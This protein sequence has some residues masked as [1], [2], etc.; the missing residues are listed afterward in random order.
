VAPLSAL[1]KA[2]A[3]L[4][5]GDFSTRAEPSGVA[6][7]DEAGD[8]LNRTAERLASLIDREQ[9]F[10]AQ[11]SHQLRTPLT[12]LQLELETGLDQGG[13][14][15]HD[16]A[17]SAMATADQ[18]SQT[19]DDVLLLSRQGVSSDSFNVEDL[20]E[21]CRSQWQGPLASVGRPLRVEVGQP[22]RAAASLPASRQIL[23]VLLDNAFRHGRGQVTLRARESHGAVAVDV[24][25][26]GSAPPISLTGR[27]SMGLP[28]ADSLASAE[29]GR[30][31]VDQRESGTRFTVLLPLTGT[32]V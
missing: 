11:A 3:D 31:L 32:G 22:L 24:L 25:D 10:S 18:L 23:H 13:V 21:Q 20:L 16:A 4:G 12:Q 28:L 17:S 7:I 1:T 26:E 6:E 15:L 29:G 5:D 30:L 27:S 2:A 14:A 19:I 8:S 9:A